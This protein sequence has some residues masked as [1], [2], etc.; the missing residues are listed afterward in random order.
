MD[1][2]GQCLGKCGEEKDAKKYAVGLREV[3]V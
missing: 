2:K 1:M 3:P